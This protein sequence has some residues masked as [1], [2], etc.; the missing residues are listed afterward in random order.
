MSRPPRAKTAR[1]LDRRVLGRAFGFLGPV[2]AV[3]AMA[4]LPIGAALFFDWPASALPTSGASKETLS[5]M[6]FAA[7]VLC[8]MAAAF[9]CRSTPASLFTIGPFTNR[10]LVG[11]VGIELVAL[12]GFVYLPLLQEV[13]GHQGLAWAQW[14][15]VLITPFLLLAAEEAR[16]AVAR[17]RLREAVA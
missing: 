11:A 6:V 1:L 13:L 9:Q 2:E 8:Q 16:K 10:L 12:L 3:L 15:P 4:M 7:I 17:M 14:W 5:T